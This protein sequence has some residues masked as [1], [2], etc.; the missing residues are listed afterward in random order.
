MGLCGKTSAAISIIL[1]ALLVRLAIFFRDIRDPLLK[2][3]SI[4]FV[5]QQF[6]QR[7][8]MPGG[9]VCYFDL[10]NNDDDEN[11]SSPVCIC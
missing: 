9:R 1:V 6:D 3:D 2:A 7:F 5:K 11:A 4:L 8:D 10:P